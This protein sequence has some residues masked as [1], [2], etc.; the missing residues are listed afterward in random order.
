MLLIILLLAFEI[1]T[2][3]L[4]TKGLTWRSWRQRQGGPR[5]G[6]LRTRRWLRRCGRCR[7]RGCASLEW[8][9]CRKSPLV[10]TS[11]TRKNRPLS[12]SRRGPRAM[13]VAEVVAGQKLAVGN[14]R[15]SKGLRCRRVSSGLQRSSPL[16]LSD[17]LCWAEKKLRKEF[18]LLSIKSYANK[19]KNIKVIL[20]F[21]ILKAYLTLDT[22]YSI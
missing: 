3:D 2:N 4:S 17:P 20:Q 5:R 16:H 6:R 21:F 1:R 9:C 18:I 15:S 8:W 11:L 13:E 19:I 14:R 22:F 12:C 10:T 7:R